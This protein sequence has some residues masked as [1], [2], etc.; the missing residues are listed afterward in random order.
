MNLVQETLI[1][2][3]SM[4]HSQAEVERI[5]SLPQ[6]SLDSNQDDP[7]VIALMKILNLYPWMLKVAEEGFDENI[8]KKELYHA[9]GEHFITEA[10][11]IRKEDK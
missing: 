9:V 6:R 2:L 1:Q 10:S 7:E 3:Q 11:K 8:A 4:G 5:L